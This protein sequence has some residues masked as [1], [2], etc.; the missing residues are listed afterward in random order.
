M[1]IKNKLIKEESKMGLIIT[2]IPI[3]ILASTFVIMYA[4]DLSFTLSLATALASTISKAIIIKAAIKAIKF[5]KKTLTNNKKHK[6]EQKEKHLS[7]EKENILETVKD[8]LLN[9]EIIPFCKYYISGI[10]LDLKNT[11]RNI[12]QTTCYNA[13]EYIE[14]LK[15]IKVANQNKATNNIISYKNEMIKGQ[16][17]ETAQY[18]IHFK[19]K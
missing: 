5:I 14:D 2:F 8:P 6:L 1:K 17:A 12:S 7:I 10:K 11:E 19:S 9:R 15:K 18:D 3:A 4:A 16:P 13:K